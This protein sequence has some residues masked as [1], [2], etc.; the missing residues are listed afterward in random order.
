VNNPCQSTNTHHIQQSAICS[1]RDA[2][3]CKGGKS[4]WNLCQHDLYA[5]KLQDK[6]YIR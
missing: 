6:K 5:V 2:A 3:T 4:D 1:R